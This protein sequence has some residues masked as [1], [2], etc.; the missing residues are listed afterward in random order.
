MSMRV[1]AG[2]LVCRCTPTP[3]VLLGHPGGPLW[4]RR[5]LGSWTIPKG[6]VELDEEPLA[7]AFREF[8]EETGL[9]VSGT[10][11][12]LT[13]IRQKG[14][15]RVLCWA[16]EADLDLQ[17]FS[18][19]LF[20]MEWPPHSGLSAS[21]PELDRLTYFPVEEALQCILPAQ[22]PLILEAISR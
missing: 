1:S 11:R 9:S 21:F 17:A 6:A 8:S 20:E 15:K 16:L 13:P 22:R 12:A 5:D 10:P 14:G 18:P 3:Q 7:A 4:R 19:G 2:L